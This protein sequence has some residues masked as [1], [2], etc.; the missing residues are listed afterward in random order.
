MSISKIS[1]NS[2]TNSN[3]TS[4]DT[5][6]GAGVLKKIQQCSHLCHI[7]VHGDDLGI[8]VTDFTLQIGHFTLQ[9]GNFTNQIECFRNQIGYF[10][11]QIG[12]FS[13]EKLD[14]LQIKLDI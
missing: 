3:F 10:T 11:N 5:K 13:N 7:F 8:P 4:L 14:I 1:I 9:S 6:P 12:R 2:S